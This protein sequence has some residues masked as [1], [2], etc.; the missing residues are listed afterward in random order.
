MESQA[1]FENIREHIQARLLSAKSEIDLAVAWFTDRLLFDVVCNKAKAGVKV[2]LLLFDDDINHFLPIDRL[3]QCGGKVFRVSEKLMHNKFCVIDREVVMSGSY[4]W[5]RKAHTDNYENITISTGD[6]F[7]ALQFVQEFN[8]IVELHFGEQQQTATDFSQIVKRLELIRQLIELGDTDDL[9]AQYRKL[10]LLNLP[11]DIDAILKLLEIKRYG[12]AVARITD[13]IA[14]FRQVAVFVD[15]EIAALQLE[16]HALE[17][18]ISNLENEKS[19][20]E[21]TIQD[22]EIQYNRVLG[23]LLIE[24]LEL[25]RKIAAAHVAE[26]PDDTEAREKKEEAENDYKEYHKS[27]EATQ[28]KPLDTLTPDE[29]QILKNRFREATKLCHPDVVAEAFKEKAETLFI[30]LK[31]AYDENNLT[32]VT[33]IFDYLKHGKPYAA[34]HVTINEKRHLRAV[35]DRLHRRRMEILDALQV[36]RTN[37]THTTLKSISD[38]Q[39]YFDNQKAALVLR[40]E[41]LKT[42]W[43]KI[44][45]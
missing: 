34:E 7:F 31:K 29:K 36:L 45:I 3:Q 12:D 23:Q 25:R 42:Q 14:R 10:A 20:I 15:P 13:F 26:N 39:I 35:I 30:E 19:E 1:Y 43:Q 28:K 37:E 44:N 9:H 11:A 16:M 27:Y 18:D 17:L 2:R 38:W 4:N 5:T 41:K 21:K 8:R 24:I 6:P 33:E 40:L 22:F 32:K